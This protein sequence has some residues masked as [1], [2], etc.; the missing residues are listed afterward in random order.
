[1][2]GETPTGWLVFPVGEEIFRRRARSWGQTCN[3]IPGSHLK[4]PIAHERLV[5][6]ACWRQS[7][8]TTE[9]CKRSCANL[10]ERALNGCA[11]TRT[12]TERVGAV[13]LRLLMVAADNVASPLA[14]PSWPRSPRRHGFSVDDRVGLASYS[15]SAD[16]LVLAYGRVVETGRGGFTARDLSQESR[17]TCWWRDSL[18]RE[19]LHSKETQMSAN[20]LP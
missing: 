18:S 8:P 15:V 9:A 17:E 11:L 16:P 2:L 1:M 6:L 20:L 4:N 5:T 14:S 13:L 12:A 10:S 3:D 7:L 19:A